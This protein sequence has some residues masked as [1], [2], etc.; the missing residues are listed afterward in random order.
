MIRNGVQLSIGYHTDDGLQTCSDYS[1]MC[2]LRD[3]LQAEFK[4]ITVQEGN[5]LTYVGMKIDRLPDGSINLLMPKLTDAIREDTDGTASTPATPTLLLDDG[6]RKLL[7][8]KDSNYYHSISAKALYLGLHTRPDILLAAS[9]LVRKVA[10]PTVSDLLKLKRVQKYLNKYPDIPFH[11]NTVSINGVE[12]HI[13]A[14]FAGHSDFRSHTGVAIVIGTTPIWI[15]SKRQRINTVN[16]T[17]SEIV[18]LSDQM[19]SAILVSDFLVSQGYD[20]PAPIIYQD[21]TSAIRLTD[22]KAKI[23]ARKYLGVRQ[24]SIS[25]LV[26][27]KEIDIRYLSTSKMWADGLTKPLFGEAFKISRSRLMGHSLDKEEVRSTLR[28]EKGVSVQSS[29]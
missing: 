22:A 10:A 25:D 12:A 14:S 4:E 26:K 19:Y 9:V 2:W 20:L 1:N 6:D 11:I 15:K 7:S 3:K 21:N 28:I 8:E 13:D 27:S 5:H 23:C 17:E 18:A 16:S 24:T 29:A